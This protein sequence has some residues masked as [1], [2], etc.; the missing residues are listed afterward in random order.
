MEESVSAPKWATAVVVAAA[1]LV[2]THGAPRA[3][4][5]NGEQ[6]KQLFGGN[7][8]SFWS[9]E[10]GKV[11][12]G[13]IRFRSGGSVSLATNDGFK[14]SGVWWLKG[15]GYCTKYKTIGGG[16]A[17]CKTI[18]KIGGNKYRTSTGIVIT[19]R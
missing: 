3:A 6:I 19:L 11:R 13:V 18:S 8:F 2:I 9:K 17:R 15:T 12:T 5:L 7:S 14:D 1:L 4:P 16:K 10:R